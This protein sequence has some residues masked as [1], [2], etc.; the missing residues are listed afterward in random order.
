MARL[1][2]GT[3]ADHDATEAVPFSSA[4]VQCRLPRELFIRQLQALAMI[5]R[6][7]ERALAVNDDPAVRLVWNDGLAK[8]PLLKRDL[9][10]LEASEPDPDDPAII[11]ARRCVDDISTTNQS[12]PIALL[13]FLY[14]LEGSTLGA[15]IL[16][17]HLTAMYDIDE[18]T[19]LA[20]Y[21][22]Y[23]NAVMPHWQQFKADM[24]AID[25]TEAQTHSVIDA[26]KRMFAHIGSVLTALSAELETAG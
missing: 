22:P 3:R 8:L 17:K 20:Y 5:H 10:A 16:R 21:S 25:L 26:A 11:A 7:L 24:N 18:T 1:R 15:T 4:M 23:G 6:A 12:D 19:G 13:G 9:A 14:V 2:A